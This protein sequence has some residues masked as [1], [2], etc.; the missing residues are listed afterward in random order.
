MSKN[1]RGDSTQRKRVSVG[2]KERRIA[3]E[4]DGTGRQMRLKI[5]GERA[6]RERMSEAETAVYKIV[7]G[8]QGRGKE[9][10]GVV[11]L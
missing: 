3:R 8:W 6:G 7:K 5:Q 4:N 11:W 10:G 2:V 1:E 9:K